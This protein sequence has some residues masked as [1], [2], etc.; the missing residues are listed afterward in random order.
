MTIYYVVGERNHLANGVEPPFKTRLFGGG[1]LCVRRLGYQ[2]RREG[3]EGTYI[4]ASIFVDK[5][6]RWP[7][8][9]QYFLDPGDVHIRRL[10][11]NSTQESWFSIT[12]M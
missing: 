9:S 11:R 10:R 6:R 12:L 5:I 2:C 7:F 8:F 1:C 3:E 4:I